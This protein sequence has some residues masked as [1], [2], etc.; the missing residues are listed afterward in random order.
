MINNLTSSLHI[1]SVKIVSLFLIW[2]SNYQG[3]SLPEIYISSLQIDTNI[4]ILHILHLHIVYSIVYSQARRVSRICSR[5]CDFR[6]H[7][8]EMKTWF[9][10]I[11]Y[12]INLVES[13]MN[14]VKFPHVS[15]NKSQNRKRK[16]SLQQLHTI[17][18]LIHQEKY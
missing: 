8:S 3:V 14:K 10:R 5:E 13:E 6:K 7:I 16:E 1:L 18:C 9:L 4:Y 15:N 2:M 12:P 17:H 11:G